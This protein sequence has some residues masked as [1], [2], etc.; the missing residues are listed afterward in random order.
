MRRTLCV[1]NFWNTTF[2]KLCPIFVST[3]LCLF[4]KYATTSRTHSKH[5]PQTQV[6][7]F[8]FITWYKAEPAWT[9]ALEG[10]HGR[11]R[12]HLE[13]SLEFKRNLFHLLYSSTSTMQCLEISRMINLQISRICILEIS[14]HSI[15]EVDKS[16]RWNK[17]LTSYFCVFY[18]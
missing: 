8:I 9:H 3:A 18:S 15:V 7:V 4:T 12:R 16:S 17:L 5:N 6:R 1:I 14:R 10:P 2:Y 13:S 11:L